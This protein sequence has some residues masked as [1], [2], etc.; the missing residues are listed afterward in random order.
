MLALETKAKF[1]IKQD[2]IKK[3]QACYSSYFCGKNY[4]KDGVK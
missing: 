1:K 2:K 3:L 4:L